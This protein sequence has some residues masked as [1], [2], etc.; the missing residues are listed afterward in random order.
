MKVICT[1]NVFQPDTKYLPD[2]TYSNTCHVSQCIRITGSGCM[3]TNTSIVT[4][5]AV[6]SPLLHCTK[7]TIHL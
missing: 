6:L 7:N 2:V 3:N 1:G 4:C 5:N